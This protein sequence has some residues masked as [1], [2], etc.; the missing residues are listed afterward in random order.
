M[1]R[2][3]DAFARRLPAAGLRA[4]ALAAACLAAGGQAHAFDYKISGFGSLVAGRTYGEC[5]TDA[6]TATVWADACTRYIADWAHDGVYTPSWSAKQ[7]SRLGVQG[8]VNFSRDLSGTAQVVARPNP[9][10][11]AS[12][13]W[14]YLTYKLDPAWTVQV[15]RK[16]LPL[17]YFSDFQD[18]GYA[19]PTIRPSPDV[20]GWDI[21][22]YNGVN[23]D[24]VN[25]LGDWTV[26]TSA[27]YGNEHSR[28]NPYSL[29]I[30]DD[31]Q[32]VSWDNITG[33]SLEVSKD[34]FSARVS[35][36]QSGFKQV[37]HNTGEV[38]PLD[39]GLDHA[40]LQRFYGVAFNADYGD[41]VG[42]SE[43]AASDRTEQGYTAKFFLLTVGRHF[44]D[45]TPA[46]TLSS[47]KEHS[48]Y[49]DQYV[50]VRNSTTS[51][52]LRYEVNRSSDLKLQLD[53]AR[54]SGPEPFAG[55][56]TAVSV[57]YDFVF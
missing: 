42:R 31:P 7:E 55:N 40:H 30:V 8:T 52:T 38:E 43:F 26:R 18:I 13:E 2:L 24:H 35:Y 49:P 57:A 28:K 22:N 21:V 37:D 1:T 29:I 33:A 53:R 23:I 32:D 17:Y 34:W 48:T 4:A 46:I 14:A 54:D 36:T 5:V 25:D 45:F 19:Y 12:L 10:D 11:K 39:T 41:W 3:H 44:G 16:R 20:Y 15:G 6:T 27:F 9:G 51:F 56:A 50:P 47:Y